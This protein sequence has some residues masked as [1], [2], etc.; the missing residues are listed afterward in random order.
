MSRLG[1]AENHSPVRMNHSAIFAQHFSRLVLLASRPSPRMEED[2]DFAARAAEAM[3]RSGPAA[4]GVR[5]WCL[6]VNDT[7][8]P[9][10]LSGVPDLA[11]AARFVGHSVTELSFAAF[12]PRA[13][14]VAAAKVIAT[15]PVVGDR[16]R[17]IVAVLVPMGLEKVRVA[18]TGML[19]PD[20]P[21]DAI[22]AEIDPMRRRFATP[23]PEPRAGRPTPPPHTASPTPVGTHPTPGSVGASGQPPSPGGSGISARHGAGQRTPASVGVTADSAAADVFRSLDTAAGSGQL[24]RVIETLVHNA[25]AAAQAGDN[26]KAYAVMH[27]IVTREMGSRPETRATYLIGIKRLQ[28]R[29]L[30]MALAR[31]LASHRELEEHILA[32]FGRLGE[33]AAAVLVEELADSQQRFERRAL[34]DVISKLKAGRSALVGSLSDPRW[35]VVRN[36]A[37][38]LGEIGGEAAVGELLELFTHAD[39]RVRRSGVAAVARSTTQAGTVDP[40]IRALQDH[41]TQ[42]RVAA[43]AGLGVRKSAKSLDALL[44][45]LDKEEDQTVQVAIFDALGR[46]GTPTAVSKLVEASEAGGRLFK[47]KS[48]AY[49][50][51]ATTALRHVDSPAARAA[52]EKLRQDKEQSVRSAAGG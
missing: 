7:E 24:P 30:L 50:C 16:G 31:H 35:Y 18:V 23:T 11:L 10:A 15:E 27:A 44:D 41:A 49:R 14:L 43:A 6:T 1:R 17:N 40:L 52:L 42:V 21:P 9:K 29:T 37:D 47:R 26:A 4:L 25:D 45:R 5:N 2:L 46:N 51:A 32:I 34:F 36:A 19:S 20:E 3:L 12:A 28:K 38:L 39:E 33:P 48:V 22:R 8:Q 13:E